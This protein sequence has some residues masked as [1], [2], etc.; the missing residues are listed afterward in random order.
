MVGDPSILTGT[1]PPQVLQKG[2]GSSKV[3]DAGQGLQ[4]N[5]HSQVAKQILAPQGVDNWLFGWFGWLAL[6]GAH[7]HT[8]GFSGVW[9]VGWVVGGLGLVLG[10]CF[11]GGIA[12]TVLVTKAL[13]S[14]LARQN[15]ELLN[16]ASPWSP[17]SVGWQHV[18]TSLYCI[19]ASHI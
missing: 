16:L 13:R 3:E 4:K 5:H 12:V 1:A 9:L 8:L 2:I 15:S 7:T 6:T 17:Q 19:M 11:L 10:G 14:P 18:A